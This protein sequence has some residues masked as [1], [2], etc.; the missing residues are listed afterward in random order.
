MIRRL[1][2]ALAAAAVIAV[3]GCKGNSAD[4]IV[5]GE[6]SSLTG[7]TATFGR[8][9]DQGVQLAIEEINAAGG[10]IGKKIRV[11][12]EDDQSKPE[13]ART[14]VLKL[15]KQDRV[16]AVL[17]EVASSRS[18]AAAPECQRAGVPMISHASTNPK[19][20]QVGDY[21][22]RICFIDPFQGSTMA[23][24]AAQTLKAK[25]AAILRDVK[26]DYSVGLADFFRDEFIRQGGKILTDVSYS[27]GD[28]DFKA[29][30]TAIRAV[31]PEVVFVPGYYTEVGLIAR[32]ARELGLA[33]P[34]LGGDGWDSAKTLEIGGDA[35]NGCYFS[36]HYAADD[37]NPAVQSFIKKFEAKYS[38]VPDAMAV[39]GYDSAL[40]LADAIKR[41]GSV[42]GPK[43][44]DA[45]A[46]TKDFQGVSGT[47]TIDK[48][49]NARKSIVVL[50]IEGGRFK[51]AQKVEP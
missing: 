26:N 8:S 35:V 20:T 3:G 51:F 28:I 40:V 11:V 1:S 21:I 31:K 29:Q 37:P 41:A 10:V 39:L 36:N 47:I 12:V 30:L 25:N 44:R 7:G 19:V 38:E 2:V 32:Q 14:A 49:R 27:E 18:L 24:F 45:I 4:E 13:E 42:E 9:S 17:G 46:A 22:F 43:L 34:L 33:V 6:Y 50:K 48:E 16:S 5:V 15:L 23:K